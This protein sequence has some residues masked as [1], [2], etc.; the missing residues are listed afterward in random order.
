V[1]FSVPDGEILLISTRGERGFTE[2]SDTGFVYPFHCVPVFDEHLNYKNVTHDYYGKPYDVSEYSTRKIRI[3]EKDIG[4]YWKVTLVSD[5]S[6][7]DVSAL[8]NV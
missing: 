8:R 5:Y 6:N 2:T 7:I 1:I 3:E 4:D